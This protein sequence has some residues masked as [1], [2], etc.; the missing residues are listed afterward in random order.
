MLSPCVEVLDG[1]TQARQQTLRETQQ[2]SVALLSLI[3]DYTLQSLYDGDEE[4]TE[5][6]TAEGGG[7]GAYVGI[8]DGSGTKARSVRR[9]KPYRIMRGR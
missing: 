4:T 6:D 3:L 8:S 1:I 9:N 2:Q 5:A 7:H